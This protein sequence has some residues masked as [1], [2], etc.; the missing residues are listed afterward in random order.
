MSEIPEFHV[1]I[2]DF[3][4]YLFE[5]GHADELVWV[6]RD[7]MWFRGPEDVLMRYPPPV[8]NKS[9]AEKV[10]NEGRERGLI[11]IT[12]VATACGYVAATVWFPKF[13]EEDVQGWSH[14]LK[15]AIRQPLPAAK[16]VGGLAWQVVRGLSGYRWYQ[17]HD[18]FIGSRRWAAA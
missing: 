3:R 7:D 10:Y 17:R 11:G 14:G 12:A 8:G 1:A 13:P 15:L 9:L 5:L 6:F 4:R 18:S 16:I 2:S